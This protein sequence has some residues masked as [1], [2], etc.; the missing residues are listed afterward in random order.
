MLNKL[1]QSEV[2][3]GIIIRSLHSIEEMEQVRKL[4]SKIWGFEDSIPTHQT[5]TAAKNGGLVL[6]AYFEDDLIGFQY[7]FPGY[8]GQTIY[9]CS[10]MLGI[11]HE[12]RNNGIGKLLKIAQR[13]E[14]LKLGYKL[15]TWT[16]DPLETANGYLNISKLGGVCSTYIENC[17]GEMEDLLNSGIS[18]DRFLVEWQIDKDENEKDKLR[19]IELDEAIKN[20]LIKWEENDGLP[21][22]IKNDSVEYDDLIFVAVPKDFRAI[23]ETNLKT[24]N[25]WRMLTREAF[26]NLFQS[27]W[28]VTGF[29]KN[30]ESD[31]P[32][33]FYVL[34]K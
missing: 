7:S 5:I 6:G 29:Y 11:D 13:E 34:K 20:S 31:M 25:E 17:Y 32:I 19:T 14:A 8:D 15:I 27:G 2:T 10:H 4:E 23:R 28:K 12:F 22:P 1:S 16:Y 9:L 26:K 30:P 33:H 18:S 3:T 21:K 24:A